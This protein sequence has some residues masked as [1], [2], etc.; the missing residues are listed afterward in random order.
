M[1]LLLSTDTIGG[2]WTYSSEL[3]RALEPH[4]VEVALACLGAELNEAQR[5]EVA[6]LE[7]MTLFERPC[8]LEWMHD[9]WSDV[10]ASGDWLRNIADRFG[11][12]LIQ[13]CSYSQAALGWNAPVILVAHSCV[14]SWWQAVHRDTPPESWREYYQRVRAGVRAADLVV[15][16]SQGM[17]TA[18]RSHYGEPRRSCVIPN[19][20][21]PHLFAPRTKLPFIISVGRLWD[22]AKN[23]A[24]L[25]RAGAGLPWEVAVAGDT[26]SPDGC[27]IQF[28]NVRML[29]R[30]ASHTL[31]AWLGTAGI[32]A[33][34]ALYEPFG[35]S[36]LEA[37]LSRCPLVL[38]DIPT[39]R[40][41]WDDAAIF[42]PPDDESALHDALAHLIADG[43]L[44]S[45]L[46]GEAFERARA[47][48]PEPMARRYVEAWSALLHS[49]QTR[50]TSVAVTSASV[51]ASTI[52]PET[53]GEVACV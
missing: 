53:A 29:R 25:A 5:A 36:V 26:T 44:R 40:E 33:L 24:R 12:D 46:A 17:L 32:Y 8:A 41:N 21:S 48:S 23:I 39:L 43:R 30:L 31:S 15:A 7:N 11:A 51:D 10:D 37:A 19:A 42:V 34:P 20:R 28:E 3:V 4:G 45:R 16:P 6:E 49:R 14:Y 50:D 2:V 22:P 47:F 9:P 27:S 18:L 35:L 13:L 52:S 38:G 1:K